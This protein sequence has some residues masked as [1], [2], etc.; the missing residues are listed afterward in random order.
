MSTTRNLLKSLIHIV[1]IL[2]I[3][4]IAADAEVVKAPTKTLQ[5]GGAPLDTI[6][7]INAPLRS[8]S[9]VVSSKTQITFPNFQEKED[10]PK[11]R[12]GREIVRVFDAGH[13]TAII[14][15][16]AKN[17]N[18]ILDARV[19]EI[20]ITQWYNPTD[21]DLQVWVSEF[22]QNFHTLHDYADGWRT[23]A[24]VG[25]KFNTKT[26]KDIPIKVFFFKDT[27]LNAPISHMQ[28]DYSEIGFCRSSTKFMVT[29]TTSLNGEETLFPTIACFGFDDR[30]GTFVAA[31]KSVIDPKAVKILHTETG[32]DAAFFTVE[33]NDLMATNS[34][35]PLRSYA[36]LS[37]SKKIR[38][39]FEYTYV[40]SEYV[41]IDTK[42]ETGRVIICSTMDFVFWIQNTPKVE[43]YIA[44]TIDTDS[45]NL[46]Y[47]LIRR[48]KLV[49]TVTFKKHSTILKST[50][51]YPGHEIILG[52]PGEGSNKYHVFMNRMESHLMNNTQ[53]GL[54][55]IFSEHQAGEFELDGSYVFNGESLIGHH[56]NSINIITM[57]IP[58]LRL[59]STTSADPDFK[60][61]FNSLKS[62]VSGF[63]RD[64]LFDSKL[65]PTIPLPPVRPDDTL[66]PKDVESLYRS[67]KDYALYGAGGFGLCI[68]CCVFGCCIK[69]MLSGGNKKSR[70]GGYRRR[71]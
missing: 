59:K 51:F 65:E 2:A 19:A 68:S 53:N 26:N 57:R 58:R 9:A 17:G 66:I 22:K 70:S 64:Q 62:E 69:C 41:E 71:R 36:V 61:E 15:K 63:N 56:A 23:P 21:D 54:T 18:Y 30:T 16:S 20:D 43:T 35:T 67:L 45:D 10:I 37:K 33:S 4:L 44:C 42:L 55:Y 8:I 52:M 13:A 34:D 14:Y 40:G 39:A 50:I 46:H 27:S 31:E 48:T 29:S 6:F 11:S 28:A 60:I 5:F 24:L 12:Q 38:G 1:M 25:M 3:S 47:A 49:K 32:V 7:K